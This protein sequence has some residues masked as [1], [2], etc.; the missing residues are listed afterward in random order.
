MRAWIVAACL[1]LS[2]IAVAPSASAQDLVKDGCV[3]KQNAAQAC[4]DVGERSCA[5]VSFGLQ[6]VAACSDDEQA[7]VC[8]GFN[9]YYVPYS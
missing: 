5:S 4:A 2:V 7:W 3:G 6:G 8:A 1:L 9:C